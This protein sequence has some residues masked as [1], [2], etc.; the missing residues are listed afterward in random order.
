M[1]DALSKRGMALFKNQVN[2]L[3]Q[4]FEKVSFEPNV[5][6]QIDRHKSNVKREI[7]EKL[8]VFKEFVDL[9]ESRRAVLNSNH[10]KDHVNVRLMQELASLLLIIRIFYMKQE[11]IELN[12][13]SDRGVCQSNM[14]QNSQHT[15]KLTLKFQ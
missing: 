7:H 1:Y 11:Q 8:M 9:E 3:D 14:M 13:I 5:R 15:E 2:K 6:L 4:A 12:E 10:Q